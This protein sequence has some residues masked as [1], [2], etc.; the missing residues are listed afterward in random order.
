[1]RIK[2]VLAVVAAVAIYG[3]VAH[4]EG[5]APPIIPAAEASEPEV[6]RGQKVFS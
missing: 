1:M 6:W 2:H 3:A 4:A 5:I